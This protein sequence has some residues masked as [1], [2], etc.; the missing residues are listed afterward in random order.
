MSKKSTV[1]GIVLDRSATPPWGLLADFDIDKSDLKK[2]HRQWLDERVVDPIIAASVSPVRSRWHIELTGSASQTGSDEHNRIL[3]IARIDAVRRY[4]LARLPGEPLDFH[5]MPIGEDRPLDK[6]VLENAA[7]RAVDVKVDLKWWFPKGHRLIAKVHPL[8]PKSKPKPRVRQFDLRVV[9]G[10]MQTFSLPLPPVFPKWMHA[11]PKPFRLEMQLDIEINEV[12]TSDAANYKFTAIGR[13][14][15]IGFVPG[16]FHWRG[17]PAN[18]FDPPS[19]L[20]DVDDFESFAILKDVEFREPVF[21]F[22]PRKS[23]WFRPPIRIGEFKMGRQTTSVGVTATL[24]YETL[25]ELE[26]RP[27][28]HEPVVQN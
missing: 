20:F 10:E 24:A 12:G 9:K 6:S 25:G 8:P 16:E 5:P 17:G 19:Q 3:S 4:L 14:D 28:R 7:D 13:G 26:L 2:L 21:R 11:L 22:G 18:R 27:E 15:A 1:D 23:V